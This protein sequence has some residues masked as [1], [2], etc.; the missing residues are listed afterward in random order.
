MDMSSQL[1]YLLSLL[2]KE[3]LQKFILFH[4][5]TDYFIIEFVIFLLI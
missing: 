1:F 3:K 4:C 2:I 5:I